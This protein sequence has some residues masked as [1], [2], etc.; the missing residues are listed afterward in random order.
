VSWTIAPALPAGLVFS[1]ANGSISGTPAAPA[2]SQAYTVTATNSG[3]TGM[4]TPTF[5]VVPAAP[6]ITQQPYGQIIAAG[7]PVI[8]TVDAAGTGSLFF[9][10]SRNGIPIPGATGT[11]CSLA[12][13]TAGDD[14]AVYTAAVSD[15]F[16][17]TTTSD[18]AKL[19]LFQ[20]LAAWLAAHPTI[21][22]AI[23]WQFQPANPA[24]VYAPPAEGDKLPWASWSASQ[25][26]DLNQ[27][28]LDM[29]DW[30]SQGA[31]Q[32]AMTPGGPDLTDQPINNHPSAN[33]DGTSTLEWVSP[34]YMWK[35]YV[36][37]VAFSL[38]LETSQQVPW[39]VTDYP[40]A[41]LKWI[42]DSAS[43][44]WYL[45]NGN[46][47]LGTYSGA[48]RPALRTD[49]RPRTSFADPRWTYPWL[50]QA[51][52]VGT[53][54][55]ATIGKTLDWMR[56]NMTHFFGSDEFGTDWDIW[57]YRGYSPISQIVNGTVDT[58]NPTYGLR[59]WTAGCHGS[60][61]F[62]NAALRVLNIPVQ[63]IWV[64]GHE[65]VYFMS[66]DR[67][68]DHA[69]DPYNQTVRASSSPSVLL[70]IDSPTWKLRF[71]K[72]ETVNLPGDETS[73]LNAWIGYTAANFK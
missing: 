8:F 14:G 40:D 41:T 60:T 3:G 65:L 18:A 22:A 59:H 1:T 39:S 24:N 20:D 61:G 7:S 12:A 36:A 66:E 46:F 31:P 33:S 50:K 52:I 62:L 11:S 45:A 56:Q 19:S 5:Q 34:T 15:A 57:Q 32:V 4:A 21:A 13:M 10:W 67:Y 23:K 47:S 54:R 26:A 63:P 16:G 27:A 37:H 69:D 58:D 64:C 17:S 38:L 68:L 30:Y 25:K 70:L 71:G 6:V 55:L 2:I 48:G 49:N 28:Y 72:D 73:P 43:M 9:Q 44:G 35:L 42:F 29:V 53:T 51:G